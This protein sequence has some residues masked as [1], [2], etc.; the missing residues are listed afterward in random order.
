MRLHDQTDK[1]VAMI[2]SDYT[3][4]ADRAIVTDV[5]NQVLIDYWN[6]GGLVT[7]TWSA[8]NPLGGTVRENKERVSINELLTP[9]TAVNK[10]WMTELDTI[11]GGLQELRD[12]GVVVLWRPFHEMN[13]GWFWWSWDKGA[14]I[15]P[16]QFSRLWRHMYDYFTKTKGLDNLLWI[17]SPDGQESEP[18]PSWELPIMHYYP[19]GDVVDIVAWDV[20]DDQLI[21]YGYDDL[22][23]TG[24]PIIFGEQGPGK[25]RNGSW[26]NTILIETI[27]KR[28][29]KIVAF[30]AW[31]SWPGNLISLIDNPNAKEL[32]NDPWVMTR[33]EVDWR[34]VSPP[35]PITPS[36]TKPPT[37]PLLPGD[38][39]KDGDVDIFDYNLII[40]H[41]GNTS[42]GNVADLDNDCDVDIFD[43]NILIQ[44]FG[45]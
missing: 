4:T 14:R 9:G 18:P 11:A 17:Y 7:M 21:E 20:Y 37:P 38:I 1:W 43:Y 42:C 35:P 19:G 8:G 32:L 22:V 36:P 5:V 3:K 15:S 24:K 23:A 25:T 40:Q 41:F 39:D 6:N 33:E 2:G 45:K 29:P 12:A 10:V 26:D 34:S 16:G 30:L 28:Y 13:G 27:K 44:N 31:S